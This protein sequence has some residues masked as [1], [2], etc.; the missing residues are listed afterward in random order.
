MTTMASRWP[1][2]DAVPR[3]QTVGLGVEKER[4]ARPDE[5]IGNTAVIYVYACKCSAG[6]SGRATRRDTPGENAKNRAKGCDQG[7]FRAALS[8]ER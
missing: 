3:V 8:G 7:K 4:R 6:E 2:L 5:Y 1:T